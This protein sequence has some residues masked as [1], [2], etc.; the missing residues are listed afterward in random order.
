MSF[1]GIS[2]LVKV[3]QLFKYAGLK[4]QPHKNWDS[5]KFKQSFSTLIGIT[6][7]VILPR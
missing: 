4:G 7:Q 3:Q 1:N 6:T 2:R 5:S